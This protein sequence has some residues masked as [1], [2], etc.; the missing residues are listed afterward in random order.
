MDTETIPTS[1]KSFIH[2]LFSVP[3]DACVLNHTLI[4]VRTVFIH[5]QMYS[6]TL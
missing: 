6:I 5:L 4:G 2:L 3:V 1:N